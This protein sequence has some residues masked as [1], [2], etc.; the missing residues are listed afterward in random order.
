MMKELVYTM[1]FKS[2]SMIF[3]FANPLYKYVGV[4]KK[5]SLFHI[6]KNVGKRIKKGGGRR[7]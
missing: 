6:L 4:K 2:T 5:N 3:N 7:F 1:I